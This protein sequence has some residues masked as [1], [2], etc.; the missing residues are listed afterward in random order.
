M[1]AQMFRHSEHGPPGNELPVAIATPDLFS[2]ADDIALAIPCLLVYTLGIE[3]LI[4]GRYRESRPLVGPDEDRQAEANRLTESTRER[5]DQLPRLVTVNGRA[6]ELLGGQGDRHG[7]T[8][9]AWAAGLAGSTFVV[10]LS[11]PG[12]P[13]V[14]HTVEGPEMAGAMRR[15]LATRW[16]PPG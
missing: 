10:S 13:A 2:R 6:V 14:T 5:A 3:L 9:R 11:W 8:Y 4:L 7:F 16:W 15:V 1:T 12:A